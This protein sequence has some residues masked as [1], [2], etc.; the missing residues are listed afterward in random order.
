MVLK[1]VFKRLQIPYFLNAFD[2]TIGKPAGF[3]R[4]WRLQKHGDFLVSVF[5]GVVVD[6][7]H[8]WLDRVGLGFFFK[9]DVTVSGVCLLYG[10]DI[11]RVF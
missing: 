1:I 3:F 4:D 6:V 11:V 5:V 9:T 2:N 10:R 7:G 8:L